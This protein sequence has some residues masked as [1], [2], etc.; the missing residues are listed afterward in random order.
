MNSLKATDSLK[1]SVKARELADATPGVVLD[2]HIRVMY[3]LSHT[4]PYC[5]L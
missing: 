2:G 5:R 3:C 4:V 1:L